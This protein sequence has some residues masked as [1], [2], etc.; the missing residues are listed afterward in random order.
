MTSLY[1]PIARLLLAVAFATTATVTVWAQDDE[2]ESDRMHAYRA[3]FAAI[4]Q[5]NWRAARRH[6]QR[7]DFP[8]ADKVLLWYELRRPG[9]D[10]IFADIARFL[11]EN[12]DWPGQRTLQERA[13]VAPVAEK[14]DALVLV[15]YGERPPR[16]VDG[17]IRYADALL[18]GGREEEGVLVLREAWVE[19]NFGHRQERSFR[20]RYAQYLRPEDSLARLDRLVWEGRLQPARRL[21]TRVD[22]GYRALAHAR[23][24]LR[25]M[26]PGVDRAI[27]LVPDEL[28]SHPGLIYERLRWR[29]EKGRPEQ[30]REL[31]WDRP[32]ELTRPDL[33]WAERGRQFRAALALGHISDAYRLAS[34]H[35]QSSGAGYAEAEWLAGWVSLRFLDDSA[36]ALGHFERMYAAVT[37]PVSRARGAYWIARAA[38]ALDRDEEARAAY[39]AAATHP[40]TFYGQLAA[41]HL[42]LGAHDFADTPAAP[43]ADARTMFEKKEMVRI[44]R[45]LG[46]LG[47][48]SLIEPFV[49]QLDALAETAGERALIA[50]LAAEMERPDLAVRI[51]RRARR[52]GELLTVTGYPLIDLPEDGAE[53]ALTLAI[54][55]QESA[56]NPGAVS[57]S[58]ARGLMQLM[59]ATARQMAKAKGLRYSA[60]KLLA[61]PD[62]NII[63]GSGYL[64][65]LL[66][67]YDGSYV[68]AL[69]AYNG[70]PGRV[71]RWMREFGDPRESAIDVIDW[72]ETIPLE[73]TRNYVQRVLEGLQVYRWRLGQ[74]DAALV[75][76]SDLNRGRAGGADQVAACEREKDSLNAAREC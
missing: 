53:Q 68:L 8:L 57:P 38:Q 28:A 7:G 61:D 55:R 13:E 27:D 56:F 30:A 12:P 72:V 66:G 37:T 63:L 34:G 52:N 46:S 33:W 59:P 26:K 44:V 15:W 35:W 58:G 70:G 29:R 50:M 40:S 3:A 41:T 73:E 76:G 22:Q 18:R 36:V 17:R 25:Y 69:A 31:L 32:V 6:A 1:P 43:G 21:M 39:E 60:R 54:I 10:A 24:T 62:Y 16:T 67:N 42:G 75:T 45:L 4:E 51:A 11:G 71:K 19:G 2:A 65:R 49:S 14:D 74:A 5:G 23:L 48:K 47:A 20:K 64:G 9:S